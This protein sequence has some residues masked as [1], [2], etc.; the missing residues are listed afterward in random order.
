M[1]ATFAKSKF[2]SDH[3]MKTIATI[4][5]IAACLALLPEDMPTPTPYEPT[6]N[7]AQRVREFIRGDRSMI[8]EAD[9]F[10][11]NVPEP[12]RKAAQ[13]LID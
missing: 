9:L 2:P 8:D 13:N 1:L 6:D 11:P 10:A 3:N 4:A 12:L 5:A 7:P